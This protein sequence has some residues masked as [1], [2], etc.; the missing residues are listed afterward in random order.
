[1]FSEKTVM[2]TG[3]NLSVCRQN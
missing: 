3:C 2:F 1:V